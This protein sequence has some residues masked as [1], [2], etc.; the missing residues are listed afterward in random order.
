[1]IGVLF[2]RLVV[3]VL[4]V[5]E[6]LSLLISLFVKV[7]IMMV[8]MIWICNKLSNSIIVIVTS[9]V[10]IINV[11]FLNFYFVKISK[12]EIFCYV[13]IYLWYIIIKCF[14]WNVKEFFVINVE[15]L[16]FV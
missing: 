8:I 6:I 1:M 16:V 7:L 2:L 4:I 10:F 12:Y 13:Y 3:K 11:I 14:L 15:K 9:I 5:F